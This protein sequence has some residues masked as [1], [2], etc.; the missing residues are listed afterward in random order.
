MRDGTRRVR[1]V[2][3]SLA[4]VLG[5]M[6]LVGVSV[7]AL[8]PNDW[9]PIEATVKSSRIES[10]RYGV[11][12]WAI[13]T[14]ATYSVAGGTYEATVDAFRN[15]DRAVVEAEMPNWQPGRNFTLHYDETDPRSVSTAADGGREATVVTSVL[16]TPLAVML[17]YFLA[18]LLNGKLGRRARDAAPPV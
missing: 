6:L 1:L 7:A 9:R 18:L 8:Y 16:L 2:V 14:D 15:T 17:S 12:Q 3:L 4:I 10:V 11:P 13:R 5:A